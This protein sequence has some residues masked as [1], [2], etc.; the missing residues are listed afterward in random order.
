MWDQYD[1]GIS[2]EFLG[3]RRAI[4]PPPPAFFFSSFVLSDG[5]LLCRKCEFPHEEESASMS[6]PQSTPAGCCAYLHEPIVLSRCFDRLWLSSAAA[7]RQSTINMYFRRVAIVAAVV[8]VQDGSYDPFRTAAA[9]GEQ[10]TANYQKKIIKLHGI[11]VHFTNL[12]GLLSVPKLL[13]IRIYLSSIRDR[14]SKYF[15]LG[16]RDTAVMPTLI[17]PGMFLQ[18]LK[19]ALC[20]KHKRQP[21]NSQ[22]LDELRLRFLP[23]SAH[24]I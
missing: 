4:V 12:F 10:I 22:N 5:L 23:V 3:T 1:V 11:R 9:F 24:T 7:Y 13:V 21:E 15:G 18:G 17:I 14:G 2:S 8:Q 16:P 20:A 6:Y 19:E